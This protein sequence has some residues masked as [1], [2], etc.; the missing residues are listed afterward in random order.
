MIQ[1]ATDG[2]SVESGFEP[3]ALLPQSRDLTTRPP[4][5]LKF[6]KET[7]TIG[8]YLRTI[9]QKLNKQ[10]KLK[11]LCYC[12]CGGIGT[13]LHYDA[14]CALTVSWHMRKPA[15]NFE[16]E[17]LKRVANNLVSRHKSHRIVKFIS[18]NRDLFEP[19]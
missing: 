16:Q 3:G 8:V 9:P 4:R 10:E 14:E 12:S 1:R 5:P 13:A 2:S 6:L 15:P 11:I 7:L 19:P 18:G 17:W